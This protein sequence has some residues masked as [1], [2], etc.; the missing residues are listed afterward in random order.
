[1]TRGCHNPPVFL[2]ALFHPRA[3]ILLLGVFCAPAVATPDAA[4]R[5]R[6]QKVA[7]HFR[8]ERKSQVANLL[9]VAG[10]GALC[11]WAAL[12]LRTQARQFLAVLLVCAGL[13]LACVF[14]LVQALLAT[15]HE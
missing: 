9:V 10:L 12:A 14:A 11:G 4:V 8:E 7:A 15:Q 13:S 3:A 6:A 5:K 2:H 1:M